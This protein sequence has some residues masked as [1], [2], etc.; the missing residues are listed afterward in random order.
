MIPLSIYSV[1]ALPVGVP[2]AIWHFALQARS[3][4]LAE[5]GEGEKIIR[6]PRKHELF[7]D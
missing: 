6:W 5:K 3:G 7:T 1:L 4:P 2:Y